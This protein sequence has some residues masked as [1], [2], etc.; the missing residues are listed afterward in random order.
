MKKIIVLCLL[1]ASMF[2]SMGARSEV[3]EPDMLIRNVAEEVL[4]AV[5]QENVDP[6]NNP[7][8]LMS[9]VGTRVLPHFDFVRMTRLAAGKDW[10]RA[11]PKQKD[12]LVTEFRN[13]LVNTY[14]NAFSRYRDQTVEVMPVSPHPD[15]DK[16]TVRTLIL[17]PG[18][19]RIAVDYEMEK[20]SDGWKVFD[21]TVEKISLA[22]VYRSIFAQQV[23]Q[24]GIEGLIKTLTD[25]NAANKASHQHEED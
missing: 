11:T 4:S 24:G 15:A 2:A 9:I 14:A 8:N 17:K 12:M 22:I 21:L 25:K 5:R 16:V 10:H 6:A 3:T 23:E 1:C 13:L 7:H 19:Q 20:T 18:A